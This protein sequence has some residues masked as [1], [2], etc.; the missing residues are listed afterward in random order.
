MQAAE[1][2]RPRSWLIRLAAVSF[3]ALVRTV[4]QRS[5]LQRQESL[6]M[7]RVL[8]TGIQLD[9]EGMLARE[10]WS[11]LDLRGEHLE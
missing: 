6:R 11:G 1:Q 10:A 3:M 4:A 9:H 5:G 2:I 8:A 7:I